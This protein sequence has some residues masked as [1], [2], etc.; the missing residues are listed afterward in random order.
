M[1]KKRLLVR[2]VL[3]LL[4]LL[5]SSFGFAQNKIL[6]GKVTDPN[7]SPVAGASV[8]LQY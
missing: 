3:P 8:E 7:G 4:L 6:K 2:N 5:V 1:R